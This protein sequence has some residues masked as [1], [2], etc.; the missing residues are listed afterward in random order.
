MLADDDMIAPWPAAHVIVGNPP[1]LGD[2]SMIDALGEEY[3]G[4]LRAAYAGRVLGSADLVCYWFEKARKSLESGPTKRVGLVAT[5]S[6]RSGASRAVLEKIRDE[7][8]IFE[9]WSD[10]PWV[11]DGASVRV[12]IVCFAAE[13]VVALPRLD[14]GSVSVINP[15]LTATKV[16][17]TTVRPLR[18]NDRR[19]FQGV[20]K[21][22]SFGIDGRLA[23]EW[24][25]APLNPNGRPNADVL[26]PIISGGELARRP[27]DKWVIDF[28]TR[29]ED[30]AALYAAPF[31]HVNRLVRPER[32][33]VRRDLYRR[34]WWRF[35]ERR[36]GMWDT[37]GTA[38][39]YIATPKVS[40]HRFFVWLERAIVPDNLVIV[41]A[42]DDDTTFGILSSRFHELWSLKKGAWIG[43][44]NDP[45]YTPT[46]TFETFP[47]PDGLIPDRA[48]D[49][50]ASDSRAASIAAAARQLDEQRQRYLNPENLVRVASEVASGFPD[51]LL[52][53]DEAA[54]EI[55]KSLTLTNLY[56][57]RPRWLAN[58]HRD[59]DVAVALAYG[60]PKNISDDDA[61]ERLFAL[62]RSRAVAEEQR[63]TARP[64][65]AKELR[66]QPELGLGVVA[67]GSQ[68]PPATGELP[69][70]AQKAS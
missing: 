7:G 27:L 18:E 41:I 67:G 62:N 45:T 40:K 65:T 2:K 53:Q 35:A 5:N 1:F 23:R 68:T 29:T 38:S 39:R 55:L 30:E 50:Y 57:E 52:P 19:S 70:A 21:S 28:G 58:A 25:K 9:A 24:L 46:S 56:N 20:T 31:E 14:G 11:L 16:D 10:I 36:P 60:W 6:I 47:F 15:D 4:R 69:D 37:I 8:Q 61:L 49:F 63:V 54:A 64:R 59:L 22:G 51:R 26:R 48:A 66:E 42:R 12:S 3:V 43:V 34:F 32:E 44:G 17:L 33:K 13:Q